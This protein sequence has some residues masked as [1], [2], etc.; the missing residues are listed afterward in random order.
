[1]HNILTGRLMSILRHGAPSIPT[2]MWHYFA[3]L[4]R[5]RTCI[6][7]HKDFTDIDISEEQILCALFTADCG[8]S[9]PGTPYF[10]TLL[11]QKDGVNMVLARADP[12]STQVYH[13]ISK[14][15]HRLAT[16][17]WNKQGKKGGKW[18]T[19]PATTTGKGRDQT[20]ADTPA[21]GF[22]G[23]K[24]YGGMD[25]WKSAD[26]SDDYWQTSGKDPWN[27]PQK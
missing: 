6:R 17:P 12:A 16:Q 27:T 24:N 18:G 4:S 9:L 21:V 19:F 20:P 1:M 15:G 8:A 22:A 7:L 14:Q 25:W 3:P 11:I 13:S 5:I 26:K 23:W 10:Q 2:P